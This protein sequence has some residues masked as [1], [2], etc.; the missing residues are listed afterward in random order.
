MD[1]YISSA[2][3]DHMTD[4]N[5]PLTSENESS[6]AGFGL[7]I[8]LKE[9]VP[10]FG[11]PPQSPRA[12]ASSRISGLMTPSPR[13]TGPGGSGGGHVYGSVYGFSPNKAGSP[14]P[15]PIM[16]TKTGA[17][18]NGKSPAGHSPR[19][20]AANVRDETKPIIEI[21][22]PVVR[23]NDSQRGF[24]GAD[25]GSSETG[26]LTGLVEAMLYLIERFEKGARPDMNLPPSVRQGKQVEAM[27]R[28]VVTLHHHSDLA[29]RLLEGDGMEV[30]RISG[31]V[32]SLQDIAKGYVDASSSKKKPS[33]KNMVLSHFVRYLFHR[34]RGI[35]NLAI[36]LM[37]SERIPH[38]DLNGDTP[39]AN[40][41]RGGLLV[42]P[43]IEPGEQAAARWALYG[44]R[45][46]RFLLNGSYGEYFGRLHPLKE[47]IYQQFQADKMVIPRYY[48]H[49]ATQF[50]EGHV[51][52]YECAKEVTNSVFA[53]TTGEEIKMVCGNRL[54]DGR[55]GC[56]FRSYV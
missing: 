27:R 55:V 4:I 1:V 25:E 7:S 49:C 42:K 51:G 22:G 9:E 8:L 47:R 14:T 31:E 17:A 48:C 18:A 19:K 39:H 40:G 5:V 34:V 30:K 32:R 43:H 24:I 41:G 16:K 23:A 28:C 3:E 54:D 21:A 44:E 13:K 15:S 38:M 11:A 53:G 26:A 45:T 36:N 37:H 52:H 6:V 2:C 12:Y 29:Q 56:D 35:P 10:E 33:R 46:Q 50:G 20:S